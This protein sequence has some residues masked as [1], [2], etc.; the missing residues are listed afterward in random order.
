[1]TNESIS[2][3]LNSI[4]EAKRAFD[5]EPEHLQRIQDLEVDQRRLGDTIATRELRIHSLKQDNDALLGKL[6]SV[7]AERDDAGFRALEEADRVS[8]LLTLVRQFVGD[9]LKAISAVEGKESVVVSKADLEAKS[10]EISDLRWEVGE[11]NRKLQQAQDDMSLA[12]EQL[13]RPFAPS[14]ATS[15]SQGEGTD[16]S[17]GREK[18][19]GS[20]NTEWQFPDSA[21]LFE[22]QSE[23]VPTVSDSA[24]I[25]PTSGNEPSEADVQVHMNTYHMSKAEGQSEGP[26]ATQAPIQSETASS[27]T[28]SISTDAV[29]N[30]SPPERN[31]DRSTF[32]T[33]RKYFDVTY[34][35]P[36]HQWLNEGGSREDYYWRPAEANV[37]LPVASQA[38]H[39]S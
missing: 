17:S 19:R 38:S 11:S 22:R 5:A 26:F 2:G 33:G 39:R 20:G 15:S 24:P 21:G 25:P 6:R 7:E 1:M 8:A 27:G 10:K 30:A 29:S 12:Q 34:F 16:P 13:T 36:L 18:W 4:A 31:R 9:G 37:P 3:F 35:V 23:A 28:A 14:A 32:F